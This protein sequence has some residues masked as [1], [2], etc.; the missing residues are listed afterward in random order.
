M[1]SQ[2][3]STRRHTHERCLFLF[4]LIQSLAFSL[5]PWVRRCSIAAP[6]RRTPTT[7]WS[8][9]IA[10]KHKR[11]HPGSLQKHNVPGVR[12]TLVRSSKNRHNA[13]S[14]SSSL[15]HCSENAFRCSRRSSH[16]KNPASALPQYFFFKYIFQSFCFLWISK[17]KMEHRNWK[18]WNKNCLLAPQ[19]NTTPLL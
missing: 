10:Q 11:I 15:A 18:S 6:S 1:Q 14:C 13:S 2:I 17:K 3:V 5:T 16:R 7:A 12:F 8:V 4:L 19:A 9:G